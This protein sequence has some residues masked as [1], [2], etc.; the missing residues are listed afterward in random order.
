MNNVLFSRFYFWNIK[1]HAYS[2]LTIQYLRIKGF[3]CQIFRYKIQQNCSI[4]VEWSRFQK[5]AII[6]LNKLSTTMHHDLWIISQCKMNWKRKLFRNWTLKILEIV[7]EIWK[8][9]SCQN[10]SET[11]LGTYKMCFKLNFSSL[12]CLLNMEV[13]WHVKQGVHSMCKE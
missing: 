5:Y 8:I 10:S 1:N 3:P 11:K 2:F 6:S 7:I 4:Y 12:Q 9:V 13:S